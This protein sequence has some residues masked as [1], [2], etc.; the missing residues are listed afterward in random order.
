MAHGVG[1]EA[2]NGV[3]PRVIVFFG[4][5][6]FE[7]RAKGFAHALERGVAAD[8]I[9]AVGQSKDVAHVF[10]AVK[11]VFDVADDLLQHVLNGDE[12][13]NTPKFIDHQRHVI[14]RVAEFAQQVVQAFALGHKHR[15]TQQGAD[16]EL[17]CALQLE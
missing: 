4:G 15:W 10:L 1:D 11:L 12:A 13:G 3:E 16:V 9:G 6:D 2:A 17:R 7:V 14:A 8:T 5:C